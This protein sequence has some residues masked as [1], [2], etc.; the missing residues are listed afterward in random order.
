MQ[1]DIVLQ[2][3]GACKGEFFEIHYSFDF[4]SYTRKV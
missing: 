1:K 2:A 4:K 3:F